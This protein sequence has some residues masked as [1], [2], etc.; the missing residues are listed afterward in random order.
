MKSNIGDYKIALPE[1][2][3]HKSCRILFGPQV[4]ITSQFLSI[5]QPSGVKTA[6]RRLA[7]KTHPDR[8][9]YLGIDEA[10]LGERFK[11]V[12]GA[13][14][15]VFSYVKEPQRY[16]ITTPSKP[17]YRTDSP[18][19]RASS[20]QRSY[21]YKGKLPS[22]KLLICQFLYYSGVI[23]LRQMCDAVVWQQIQRPYLGD[24]A[25]RFG[26][27]SSSDIQNILRYRNQGELFGE[28]ALRTG[29]LSY[30]QVLVLVGRQKSI[31]PQIGVY[32][33]DRGILL[34]KKIDIMAAELKEHN[35][36]HWFR[37]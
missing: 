25:L 13:Y 3:L 29:L 17:R 35:R 36:K 28:F 14:E 16:I 11:K 34:Q 10:T 33:V 9:S 30:Y 31:Q 23:S 12:H 22:K 20:P 26:W 8:A 27:L 24:I 32:F 1:E 18:V 4:N 7:M 37:K 2:Q 19:S 6:Y 5:L 21:F 15:Q